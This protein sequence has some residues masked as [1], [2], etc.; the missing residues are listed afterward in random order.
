MVK[1]TQDVRSTILHRDF[2]ADVVERLEI[3]GNTQKPATHLVEAALRGGAE[4]SG[5]EF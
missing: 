2:I 5:V 3:V 4:S 1:I